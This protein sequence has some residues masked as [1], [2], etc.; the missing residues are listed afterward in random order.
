[1]SEDEKDDLFTAYAEYITLKQIPESIYP[2]TF[3]ISNGGKDY[4]ENDL[5]NNS[6]KFKGKTK[7]KKQK[8]QSEKDISKINN[9]YIL[10]DFL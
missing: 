4:T 2:D 10:K 9:V 5:V 6:K 1:M 3:K 8:K 7:N